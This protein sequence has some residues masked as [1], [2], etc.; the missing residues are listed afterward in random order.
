MIKGNDMRFFSVGCLCLLV[1]MLASVQYPLKRV[2]WDK[3]LSISWLC[4]VL[5]EI[6]TSVIAYK[7]FLALGALYLLAWPCSWRKTR[8]TARKSRP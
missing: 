2:P 8:R 5:L 1:L 3:P 4:M 6:V 7:L